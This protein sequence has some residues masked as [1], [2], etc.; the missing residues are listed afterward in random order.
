MGYLRL[1]PLRTMVACILAGASLPAFA[2]DWRLSDSFSTEA[3]MIHRDNDGATAD[4]TDFRFSVTPGVSLNGEGA[5]AQASVDYRPS[6]TVGDDARSMSHRLSA[7]GSLELIPDSFFL[8]GTATAGLAARSS[9]SDS[10]DSLSAQSESSQTFGLTISPE[11][12]RRMGS[13]ADFV[14]NNQLRFTTVSGNSSGDSYGYTLNAGL[15]TGSRFGRASGGFNLTQSATHNDG[16]GSTNTNRSAIANASYQL[17]QIWSVRGSAGY[18]E[19]DAASN[20]RSDNSGLTWTLGGTWTP[21][22]RTSLSGEYGRTFAGESWNTTFSHR[23][24]RTLIQADF[25]RSLTDSTSVIA[26]LYEPGFDTNGNL[27]INPITGLPLLDNLILLEPRS[28]NSIATTLG[29]TLTYTGKRS[30]LSGRVSLTKREYELNLDEEKLRSA[31]LSAT[32]N[33]SANISARASLGFNELNDNERTYDVSFG[34]NR[35]LDARSAVS[36]NL[37]HRINEVDGGNGYSEQR[38]TLGFSTSFL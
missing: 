28:E 24:R 33:L 32:R 35:K 34:L 16:S 2:G 29:T 21:N 26:Q 22:P 10:V 19:T 38:I 20:R 4:Q 1:H 27:V 5:R 25:Q 15:D 37:T 3:T 13:Y 9:Q 17:S 36:L 12:R 6:F 11:Y 7:S 18:S 30:T 8:R 14:S 31:T 23:S